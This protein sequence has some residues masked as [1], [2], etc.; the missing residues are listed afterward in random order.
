MEEIIPADEHIG[1]HIFFTVCLHSVA[2]EWH[3][4]PIF[5]S[6]PNSLPFVNENFGLVI[7]AEVRLDKYVQ[8][9]LDLK[10]IFKL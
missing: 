1:E 5:S 10:Q 7:I 6:L 9:R 3:S 4:S 8:E 2:W